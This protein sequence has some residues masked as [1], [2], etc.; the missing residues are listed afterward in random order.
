MDLIAKRLGRVKPSPTLALAQRANELKRAGRDIISLS[1]GEPDFATPQ[2]IAEAAIEA[3]NKG[4]TR[5]TP[6]AGTPE[7]KAAIIA[8]F[9]RD[10][11]LT[12]EPG[13]VMASTG[14]KQV[15]FNALLATLNPGDEV[16]IPAPYWVS[17]PDMVLVAEG[18]PVIIDCPQS[19]GFK[20]TAPQ[21]EAALSPRSKWVLLNSPSN[22]TGAVYGAEELKSLAEVLRRHP[23]VM[24][25]S[26]DIYEAILFDG[27]HFCNIL[28][29]APD[30]KERTL[31]VNG[32]SKAYAMT[33]WRL[34]YGA[35]P[36]SLITAMADL[37]SHSTSNPCSLT[38]A[39]AVAALNGPQDFLDA[40][41]ATYQRRRDLV[42]E[43]LSRIPGLSC[44]VPGGAFYLYVGCHG[45]I[46]Q[47]TPAGETLHSD[48]DIGAY[49]LEAAEVAAVPGSAFG[50]S[51]YLRLS[52]A[53][54]DAD[55]E[56]ACSRIAEAVQALSPGKA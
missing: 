45:L 48:D 21:L 50:L 15:I 31:I 13:E 22:P 1:V 26:D 6:V 49:L 17:Y 38:Q 8:K 5:Y 34:G 16:I 32:V 46:G 47:V 28:D 2:W 55:L 56:K 24:I 54:D 43:R 3:L 36:K 40:W 33:G 11:N 51:P 7:L 10:Q 23:Q 37:Q 27:S 4:Q 29:V 19:Q 18:Q 52:T 9:K 35:G 12:Y 42:I 41:R 44:P 53:L 30:L 39:A 20:L 25:L 14:G